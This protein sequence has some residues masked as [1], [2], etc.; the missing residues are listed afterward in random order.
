MSNLIFSKVHGLTMALRKD[1]S[2]ISKVLKKPLLQ[3]KW[4]REPEFMD[5]LENYLRPDDIFFDLGCNIGYVSLFVLKNLSKEGFLYAIDPDEINIFAFKNSIK[6]NNLPN[7]FSAEVIAM[8]SEDGEIGFEFSNKSN[9]HRINNKLSN[10]YI[11]YEVNQ[12]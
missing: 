4:H 1:D 3:R 11:I 9:L 2:G 5:I 10:V 8:S 12:K 7:N 6:N